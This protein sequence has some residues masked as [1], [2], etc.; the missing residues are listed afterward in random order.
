MMD[1][2]NKLQ[3]SGK[4]LAKRNEKKEKGRSGQ[5]RPNT[6][7]M[8]GNKRSRKETSGCMSFPQLYTLALR[9]SER[10]KTPTKK[11]K[12]SFL[13]KGLGVVNETE[14]IYCSR[15]VPRKK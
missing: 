13:E 12:K 9:G 10:K 5:E 1:F 7:K 11:P 14:G 6:K 8:R 15:R 3:G 4:I 2:E